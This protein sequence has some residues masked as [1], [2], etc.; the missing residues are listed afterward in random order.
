[1]WSAA[2][3]LFV[4]SAISSFTESYPVM[5]LSSPYPMLR[6]Y[7]LMGYLLRLYPEDLRQQ[8]E[9]HLSFTNHLTHI[10][11]N[12]ADTVVEL[13]AT[14]HSRALI[15]C[16]YTTWSSSKALLNYTKLRKPSHPIRDGMWLIFISLASHFDHIP[17]PC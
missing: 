11:S 12:I 14:K 17:F 16:K 7:F 9:S 1:M 5:L 6:Q 4:P 8:Y 3:T 2:Q 15:P 13:S 10:S